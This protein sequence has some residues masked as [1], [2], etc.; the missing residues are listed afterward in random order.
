MKNTVFNPYLPPTEYVPDGEPRVFG[1]R[2]Y[3]Y[4]SHDEADNP[5]FCVGDYVVWSAP[6]EDLSDWRYEGVSFVRNADPHNVDGSRAL[7]AP[8]VVQGVDGKY[9]LY[10]CLS[11]LPEFGVAVSDRPGG[12]FAFYGHVKNADGSIY[13]QLLP[14]DPS[15]LVD[16]DGRVYL[17][18]GFCPAFRNKPMGQIEPS[19]GCMVLELEQDMLTVKAGPKLV[20]PAL[21]NYEGTGFTKEHAYFEAP[22]MRKINGKYYLVYSSQLKHELCYAISDR[23]DG[24]F[25][26]GGTIVSSGN[27]GYAGNEKPTYYIGNNHGGL[28]CVKGQWYV[29]YHRHTH[30]INSSR[31]GCAELVSFT[32]DG[33]IPQVQTTS[34]GL[35]GKPLPGRG[36]YP[37]YIACHLVR[38]GSSADIPYPSD[39]KETEPYIYE[40]RTGEI[41][42][43]FIAH[44]T[45]GVKWGFRDF[46]F[47]KNTGV[48]LC[49]RGHAGDTAQG[50][51]RIYADPQEQKLLAEQTVELDAGKEDAAWVEI[52]VE[53]METSGVHGLYLVYEGS[54]SLDFKWME[55]TE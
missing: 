52:A 20:L 1:D 14:Y 37:A 41:S 15:V 8:D 5:G 38:P 16:E 19:P 29:F 12:P 2:L 48:I 23:S 24:D 4:G 33:H 21:S 17:Y 50:K 42:E 35:G 18:Y 46:Y 32:E 43:H 53:S 27:I 39:Y 6:C 10:Y 7:F 34:Y 47:E 36:R 45:D 30:A 22:S 51:I 49:L 55:L 13:D 31:Q 25:V 26:Y 54:G 44:I 40:E 11:F 9:Y 3:L 28:V